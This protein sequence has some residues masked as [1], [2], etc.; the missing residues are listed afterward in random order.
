MALGGGAVVY[1]IAED[2]NGRPTIP[3]P[4]ELAGQPERIDQVVHS[5]CAEPPEIDIHDLPRRQSGRSSWMR[6]RQYCGTAV[7]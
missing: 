3:A 7:L 6:P 2:A 5:A 4:I 1:R